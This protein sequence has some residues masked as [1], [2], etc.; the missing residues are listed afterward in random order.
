M[1]SNKFIDAISGRHGFESLYYHR[2]HVRDTEDGLKAG[3]DLPWYWKISRFTS[4]SAD[5]IHW[6]IKTLSFRSGWCRYDDD[7]SLG[8]SPKSEHP[9]KD[10]VRKDCFRRLFYTTKCVLCM[11]LCSRRHVPE[12]FFEYI[13]VAVFDIRQASGEYS[14]ENWDAVAVGYGVF[15][16][17]YFWQYSDT[18]Y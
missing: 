15:E 3:V 9:V 18:S 13:N 5:R 16:N 4:N 12:H 2:D 8:I 6:F 1:M 7:Y 10:M 14:G 11:F 17:W